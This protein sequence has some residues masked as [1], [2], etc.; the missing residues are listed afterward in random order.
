M[1]LQNMSSRVLAFWLRDIRQEV[2]AGVVVS[3]FLGRNRRFGEDS[4]VSEFH[5]P[6]E[7]TEDEAEPDAEQ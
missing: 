5:D 4:Q 7:E 1:H 6:E 2:R 3:Q